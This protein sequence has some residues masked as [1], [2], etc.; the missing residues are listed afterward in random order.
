MELVKKTLRDELDEL[1]EK[2]IRINILGRLSD[3]SEEL[4]KIFRAKNAKSAKKNIFPFLR[5]CLL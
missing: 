5:T 1:H 4:Q 2:N 3:F